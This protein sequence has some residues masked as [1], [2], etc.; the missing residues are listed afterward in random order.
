[1]SRPKQLGSRHSGDGWALTATATVA[2]LLRPDI[3]SH[4]L[5]TFKSLLAHWKTS[6]K[7]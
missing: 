4:C 5:A 3:I 2:A 1:M 7:E 6:I